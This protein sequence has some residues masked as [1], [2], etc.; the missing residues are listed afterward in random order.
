MPFV[1]TWMEPEILMLSEISQKEKDKYRMI[2]LTWN[3]IYGTNEPFHRKE[4]RGLGEQTCGCLGGGV[5]GIGSLG[6]TGANYCSWNG[7]TMSSCCVAMRTMS[8]H[9]HGNTTIGGKR[10]YTCMCNLVPVLY[11]RKK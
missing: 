5:G 7:F 10:M 6:L 9:L 4:N 11:S 2:S 1:A 3:L 8:R